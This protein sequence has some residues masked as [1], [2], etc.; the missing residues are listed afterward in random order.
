MNRKKIGSIHLVNF[1][2]I[3]R[4][5]T[6]HEEMRKELAAA[7]EVNRILRNER[8][9]LRDTIT[10]LKTLILRMQ[11]CVEGQRELLKEYPQDTIIASQI[12][13]CTTLLNRVSKI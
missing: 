7:Y 12:M 11:P 1:V 9:A 2:E 13:E 5:N 4:I 3:Y 8:I 6:T 10:Q